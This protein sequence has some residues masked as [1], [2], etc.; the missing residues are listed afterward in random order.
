[1]ALLSHVRTDETDTSS[2]YAPMQA[3]HYV[4]LYDTKL[5]RALLLFMHKHRNSDSVNKP[6]EH[7]SYL[8]HPYPTNFIVGY[9][10]HR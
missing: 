4:V 6:L 2:T 8:W 1:M 3:C 9:G 5:H 10:C 7:F